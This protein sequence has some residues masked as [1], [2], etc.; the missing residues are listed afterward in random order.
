MHSYTKMVNNTFNTH[1]I[2][3]NSSNINSNT[4]NSTAERERQRER[5]TH[6]HTHTYIL[7]DTEKWG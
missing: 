3:L 5:E 4:N 7:P 2:L 6:T 1:A